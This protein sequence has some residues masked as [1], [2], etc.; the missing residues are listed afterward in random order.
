[1]SARIYTYTAGDNGLHVNSYLVELQSGVVAVDAGLLNS[2]ARAFRARLEAL[3]KPLLGVLV[4]HPHPDHFNGITELVQGEEVPIHA[5]ADVARV[6][7]ATADAKRAQWGPVYGEEWPSQTVYPNALVDDGQAV[8][9]G[10]AVFRAHDLG[11]GESDS[12][13]IWLLEGPEPMAFVG[14][15]V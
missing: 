1:M 11:A 13:T 10:R 9:L 8:A 7:R 2:D 12:E 6:I 3:G 4:T 5:T 15:F 14:D